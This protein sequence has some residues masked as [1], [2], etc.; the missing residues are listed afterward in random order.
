[1]NFKIIS[2]NKI[3]SLILTAWLISFSVSAQY[4]YEF[5][6]KGAENQTI[7]MANYYGAQT[8]YNDT[9]QADAKGVARFKGEG[10]KP[11]GIYLIVLGDK[12]TY[13]E[14]VINEPKVVMMTSATNPVKDMVVKVSDENKAFYSYMRFV[15]EVQETIKSLNE[16]NATATKE[17]KVEINAKLDEEKKQAEIFKANYLKTNSTLFAAKVLSTS[18]EITVPEFKDAEGNPDDKKRFAYYKSHYF[19]NVDLS[20]DRLLRTPVL[21]RKIDT[22]IQKLTPQIPDSICEAVMYMTNQTNDSSLMYKYIVQYATNTYQ[23]SDIMGMDAVFVCMAE[24]YYTKGKAYWVEEEPLK[25][26]I[27]QYNVRKNLIIG[28]KAENIILQDTSGNWRSMYDIDAKYTILI[29]WAPDCGH[30]K[31]EMPKLKAFYDE[32]KTKGVEVYSVSTEYENEEGPGFIKKNGFTWIDVSD[33]PELGQNAAKYI[34]GGYTTLNSLKFRDY[35]D[36]FSTPQFYILDENK[37]IIAKRINSEQIP[38]FIENY[39]KNQKRRAEAASGDEQER[40][41]KTTKP[42]PVESKESEPKKEEV[43]AE[44]Q[45]KPAKKQRSKKSKSN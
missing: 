2:M 9:T 37:V 23:S 40:A 24:N 21:N 10:V 15:T 19:D 27:D 6:I 18:D 11:G 45:D 34:A 44:N 26:I 35:W 25:E 28:K 5:H 29:F 43:P 13:F 42:A 7:Y 33:S 4:D 31:K 16:Q 1:M 41:V 38:G 22:Y 17:Q 39:E 30:C 3:F 12:Q 36:L 32:Y 20:D 8:Y 14:V